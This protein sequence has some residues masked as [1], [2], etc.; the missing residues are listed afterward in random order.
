[1]ASHKLERRREPRFPSHE[2]PWISLVNFAG[3]QA[4]LLDVSARGVLLRMSS[5]PGHDVF[6]RADL[7]VRRPRLVLKLESHSEV[8]AAGQVIRCVP[9]RTSR[10]PQYEVAFSFD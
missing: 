8:Q 3:E 4:T 10:L 9:V 1:L 2:V 6:K 5:R 7:H